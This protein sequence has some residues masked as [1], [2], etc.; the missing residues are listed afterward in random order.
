MKILLVVNFSHCHQIGNE[1]LLCAWNR[2]I[3]R[4]KD[5]INCDVRFISTSDWQLSEWNRMACN[6]SDRHLIPLSSP[7]NRWLAPPSVIDADGYDFVFRMD[8]DAFIS[9]ESLNKL[10][11]YIRS[12]PCID[13]ISPSN[14]TRP[15][16]SNFGR[17]SRNRYIEDTFQKRHEKN[18]NCFSWA[19]WNQV[20][21]NGDLY[22]IK[23][24][25]FMQAL[26][27]YK[28]DPVYGHT[29]NGHH[30]NYEMKFE[31]ICKLLGY[32]DPKMPKDAKQCRVFWDGSLG[33][34]LWT[35]MCA[36]GMK[37][38]GMTGDDGKSFV[39]KNLLARAQWAFK[40]GNWNSVRDEVDKLH[41]REYNVCV[42]DLLHLQNGY[43]INWMFQPKES[44]CSPSTL[45]YINLL[46]K[47]L[48]TQNMTILYVMV[49]FLTEQVGEPYLKQKFKK[50][51]EWLIDT[52]NIDTNTLDKFKGQV[53]LFYTDAL[54]E[55]L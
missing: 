13:F 2:W 35:H 8:H 54:K 31:H 17:P 34:D 53:V 47:P 50:S 46:K 51:K 16:I 45:R 33:T 1:I 24:S 30:K 43:G 7:G 11:D 3:G 37:S 42:N 27:N 49:D 6:C 40:Y 5:K 18:P 39:N 52:H 36:L 20:G 14:C 19:P 26:H 48:I 21:N 9:V 38:A 41:P 4:Y 32:N 44:L 29:Y 25:F 12:N 55:Y 22:G 10:C 28:N 15:V 23:R